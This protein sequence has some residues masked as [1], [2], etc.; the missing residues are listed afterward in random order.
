MRS[1]IEFEVV[2]RAA[3]DSALS[4]QFRASYQ[5]IVSGMDVGKGFVQAAQQ[6]ADSAIQADRTVKKFAAVLSSESMV[7]GWVIFSGAQFDV[8]AAYEMDSSDALFD[9]QARELLHD[10]PVWNY[11]RGSTVD[12]QGVVETWGGTNGQQPLPGNVYRGHLQSWSVS[13]D[14]F[15]GKYRLTAV[16]HLAE[17]ARFAA[18]DRIL[19]LHLQDGSILVGQAVKAGQ[20]VAHRNGSLH[21]GQYGNGPAGNAGQALAALLKSGEAT[22]NRTDTGAQPQAGS[23]LPADN[24]AFRRGR[25]EARIVRQKASTGA[26]LDGLG[27]FGDRIAN[28]RRVFKRK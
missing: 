7:P 28:A 15:S 23:D 9:T 19:G 5:A 26:K 13:L 21:A 14:P 3:P 24:R 11:S 12:L 27:T 8:Q 2:L 17:S 16:V 25:S 4:A 10:G 22:A 6:F 18:G 1:R 20:S